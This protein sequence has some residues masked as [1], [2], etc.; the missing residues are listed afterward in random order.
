[1]NINGPRM[2]VGQER[3]KIIDI[4]N[5]NIHVY[6]KDNTTVFALADSPFKMI[7]LEYVIVW[8]LSIK[9]L[10]VKRCH[11]DVR[12]YSFCV[13]VVNIWNSLPN[14]VISATSVNSFKNRLDLFWVD[15]EVLYNYKANIT[16]N[17]GIKL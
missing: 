13:R 17:R 10:V 15:Q 3:E 16:G 8:L 11:Y 12:K 6:G 2:K 14:E 5:I 7:L 4:M 9:K 1:M